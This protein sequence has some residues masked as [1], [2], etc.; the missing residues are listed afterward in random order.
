MK[1]TILIIALV[2]ALA[3]GCNTKDTNEKEIKEENNTVEE[4]VKEEKKEEAK[5]EVKEDSKE[6]VKDDTKDEKEENSRENA[7]PKAYI[8]T[9]RAT[10]SDKAEEMPHADKVEIGGDTVDFTVVTVDGENEPVALDQFQAKDELIQ[11]NF[12]TTSC[13][14]CIAEM[15]ELVELNKRDDINVIAIGVGEA[16]D[17]LNKFIE[18]MK[19]DLPM[20]SDE[21]GD[22]ARAYMVASV[23]NNYY[24]KDGKIVGQLIGAWN[25]KVLNFVADELNAGNDMPDMA[26]LQA[27]YTEGEKENKK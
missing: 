3:I 1:R 2:M 16:P 19:Y 25:S 14:Y 21:N 9:S 10:F 4:T 11:L 23:P 8:A 24:I 6:E 12:F 27:V 22:A 17:K 7:D 20:F 18:N 15:P 5:E 13:T 26:K